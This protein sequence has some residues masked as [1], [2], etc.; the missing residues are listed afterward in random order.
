MRSAVSQQ[1]DE[2]LRLRRV[3]KYAVSMEVTRRATETAA[4]CGHACM[5]K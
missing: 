5:L 3:G 2:V 1:R 4:R